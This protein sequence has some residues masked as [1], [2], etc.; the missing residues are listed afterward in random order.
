M[1]LSAYSFGAKGA[2]GPCG[3]VSKETEEL[4]ESE[5]GHKE[6]RFSEGRLVLWDYRA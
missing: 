2:R 4:A 1:E 5:L 6:E 3:L